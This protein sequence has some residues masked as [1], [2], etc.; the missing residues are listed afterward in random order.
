MWANMP[1][2][3]EEHREPTL[4]SSFAGLL[5]P[6]LHE[7]RLYDSHAYQSLTQPFLANLL[8]VASSE[9]PS[10]KTLTTML[11][12]RHLSGSGSDMQDVC[13]E[14]PLASGHGSFT[15]M[16]QKPP[17]SYPPFKLP[18]QTETME[19]LDI[20]QS[21]WVEDRYVTRSYKFLQPA[22]IPSDSEL[23]ARGRGG[24]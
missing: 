2:P 21:C 10:L 22:N 14:I 23:E 4:T 15:Y 12:Y 16:V 13:Q 11:S 17:N 8:E 7:L 6:H 3:W 1:D 9:L 18:P 19:P 24:E 5:P 20:Y